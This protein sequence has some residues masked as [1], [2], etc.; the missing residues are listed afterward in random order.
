MAESNIGCD[1]APDVDRRGGRQ[2]VRASLAGIHAVFRRLT[3]RAN[4]KRF[5]SGVISSV[6][7][8]VGSNLE[9]RPS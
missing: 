2:H 9:F 6:H 1:A 5:S 4:V 8:R 7:G 3:G